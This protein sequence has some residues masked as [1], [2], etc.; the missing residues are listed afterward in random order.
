MAR[1]AASVRDTHEA[2][3]RETFKS[4][5]LSASAACADY[6]RE[7]IVS[8]DLA[9]GASIVIDRIAAD[10][11]VSHTPVRE[12]IRRL[13]AEGLVTYKANH[14]ARVRGLNRSEFEELVTLR[15]AIEPVII[16]A[17]ISVAQKGAF[18]GANLRLEDWKKA[19]GAKEMLQRQ[20][21]F[22]RALYE[23][24]GLTRSIELTDA[25]WA[26]IQRYHRHS[27]RTSN[28]MRA[29]DLAFK[30]R[31]LAACRNRQ[32]DAAVEALID[33]IEWGASTVRRNLADSSDEAPDS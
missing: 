29:E 8:G 5:T 22:F 19:V 2:T 18:E 11:G 31:I 23:P 28:E 17:A 7:Q 33:A 20:W 12:A 15:K 30:K 21:M 32:Q 27:W 25:N 10:I 14:G 26:L 24:S 16:K 6:L 9:D 1:E 3:A 4:R 13:E